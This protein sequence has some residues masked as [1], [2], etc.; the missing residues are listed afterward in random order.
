MD[1]RVCPQ[2]GVDWMFPSAIYTQAYYFHGNASEFDYDTAVEET[3]PATQA[4]IQS[5]LDEYGQTEDCLFLDVKVP[6]KVLESDKPAPVFLWYDTLP[7]R[8]SRLTIL[9]STVVATSGA[10]SILLRSAPTRPVF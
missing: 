1:A 10:R 9:G 4:R 2:G 7:G 3:L 6:R 8:S 5:E